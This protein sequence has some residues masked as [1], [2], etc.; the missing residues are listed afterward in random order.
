MV[1]SG[2]ELLGSWEQSMVEVEELAGDRVA[3]VYTSLLQ[4]W[5]S[6]QQ[7]IHCVTRQRKLGYSLHVVVQ[8][9]SIWVVSQQY[10]V[11]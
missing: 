8:E 6:R 10:T 7:V 4:P 1:P 3:A 9:G 11:K 2:E 5:L